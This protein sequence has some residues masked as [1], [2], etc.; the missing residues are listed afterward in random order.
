MFGEGPDVIAKVAAENPAEML[1]TYDVK[2]G[3]LEMFAG[4][5]TRDEFNFDAHAESFAYLAW[6]AG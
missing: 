4:S 1:T 6:P 5:A 2:P 3:E